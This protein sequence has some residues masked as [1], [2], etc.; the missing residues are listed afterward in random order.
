M[1]EILSKCVHEL[2]DEFVNELKRF[3]AVHVL[4]CKEY[5][6]VKHEDEFK[7]YQSHRS[8]HA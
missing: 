6:G 4:S 5:R 7:W 2:C 3:I 8:G 1:R